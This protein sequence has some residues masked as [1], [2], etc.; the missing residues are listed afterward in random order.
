MARSKRTAARAKHPVAEGGP[1]AVW[2][3]RIR[4]TELFGLYT[5]DLPPRSL[6]FGRTPILYGENGLG[7]TNILRILFHLLSPADKR[8]HRSALARISFREVEVWLSNG[9][10][11]SARRKPDALIGPMRLEV[12]R[13]KH[14]NQELIAAWDF[15]PQ[16]WAGRETLRTRTPVIAPDI[17]KSLSAEASPKARVRA[18]ESFLITYAV[19]ESDPRQSEEAFLRALRENVPPVYFMSADRVLSSDHVERDDQGVPFTEARGLRPE[20]MIEKG[21]QRALQRAIQLASRHLAQ[22]GVRATSQGSQSMHIIYYNLMKRIGSRARP[23]KRRMSEPL[24]E[25][26]R[27]LLELSSRYDLYAKYGLTPP[28]QGTALVAFLETVRAS[29]RSVATEVL[30]PYVESLSEQ[31]SAFDQAYTAI[32]ILVSTVNGFLYDKTVSFS[33]AEGLIVHN[34]LGA[35]VNPSDLSSGEQQLMLLFCY[36]VLATAGGIF[37]IDE[38]EISLNIKWQRRLISALEILDLQKTLQ[39]V[40][41]SHS[42]EILAGHRASVNPLSETS[43]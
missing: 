35:A 37:I 22:L 13:A 40:L 24:S 4:L 6:R 41:A 42:M 27:R 34:R 23:G 20:E 10:V 8:N 19:K 3:V 36:V 17:V 12:N 28:L 5:Y 39:F 2:I 18:L 9:I 21:R 14:G 38:P 26:T 25:L 43:S 1:N 31:A 7:K 33:L 29:E 15:V 30:R 16:E 32:D 11:V